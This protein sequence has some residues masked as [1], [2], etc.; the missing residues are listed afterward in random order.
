MD[1]ALGLLR[2]NRDTIRG[3]AANGKRAAE[4]VDYCARL[5]DRDRG[6]MTF[7]KELHNRFDSKRRS[8]LRVVEVARLDLA[9][10]VLDFYQEGVEKAIE[11]LKLAEVNCRRNGFLEL[12]PVCLYYEARCTYRLGR[13]AEALKLIQE[14]KQG[15]TH[16]RAL[17]QCE[18]VEAWVQFVRG[19]LPEAA[20]A[21]KR[22]CE[23]LGIKPGEEEHSPDYVEAV[24]V[25]SFLGRI[26]REKGNYQ[27]AIEYFRRALVLFDTHHDLGHLARGR[28][29]VQLAIAELQHARDLGEKPTG[30]PAQVRRDMEN[31]RTRASEHLDQ[32]W[33]IYKRAG[34]R[35]WMA[36]VL[37]F[38]AWLWLDRE[39]Y[40]QARKEAQEALEYTEGAN[41]AFAA[42]RAHALITLCRIEIEDPRG[43]L[44]EAFSLSRQALDQARASDRRRLNLR[45]NVARARVLLRKPLYEID[46][47]RDHLSEAKH[48]LRPYDGDYVKVELEQCVEEVDNAVSLDKVIAEVTLAGLLEDKLQ[49]TL[50]KVER[51]L[52]YYVYLR[53]NKKK[54]QTAH[55]LG[56][57]RG[58]VSRSVGPQTGAER[59]TDPD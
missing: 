20:T 13:Y 17:G 40:S 52:I 49:A 21:L 59:T 2:D 27:A 36:N 19:Y 6:E 30:N 25:L 48:M 42:T 38:R 57:D 15:L 24:N 28:V 23:H 51:E 39:D 7:V 16:P 45:A 26:E 35:R 1:E 3:I 14:A 56:T 55:A 29:L 8:K 9:E 12:V 22:A 46:Q 50:D 33:G 44:L 54:N 58:R 34:H 47:A 4:L 11:L 18:M 5:L 43:D 53:K 10:A 31:Y 41:Q 37:N 32:A